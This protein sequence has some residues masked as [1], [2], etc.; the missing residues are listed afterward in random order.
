M[1]KTKYIVV[2]ASGSGTNFQSLIDQLHTNENSPIAIR[3]LIASK[4]EIKSIDRAQNAQIPVV[5][6]PSAKNAFEKYESEMLSTLKEWNPDLIV[7]AGFLSL[8]PASVIDHFTQKIINIH[9]ALLPKFGGK[10]MFGKHVHQAVLE[11]K[12]QVS[13]CTVHYVTKNYDEGAVIM[14]SIV[15]IDDNDNVE[16]LAAKVLV[17]EHQLL[18]EVVQQILLT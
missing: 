8:L 11:A 18:A 10:G 5:V 16:S 9:P 14:Q 3:G 15:E 12:E 7:L 4:S 1:I 6:L 2:F 17:K 13:G